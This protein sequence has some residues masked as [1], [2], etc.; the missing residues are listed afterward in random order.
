MATD[1]PTG[2][3]SLTNPAGT[4]KLNSPSHASQHTNSN[5]AIE[6]IEAKVGINSSAVATSIDYKIGRA[7]FVVKRQGGTATDWADTSDTT[8]N[9]DIAV[10]TSEVQCGVTNTGGTGTVTITF[11]QAFGGSPVVVAASIG[12]GGAATDVTI[13][14]AAAASCDIAGGSNTGVYWIAIGPRA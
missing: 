1:F 13:N 6:A 2:L 14:N 9:R 10:D 12:S 4:N 3:D 5:D 7:P 8:T 11:P